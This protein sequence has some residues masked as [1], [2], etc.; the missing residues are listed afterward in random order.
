M[1]YPSDIQVGQLRVV[2]IVED[3]QTGKVWTQKIKHF[4]C[5]IVE[6]NKTVSTGGWT[7]STYTVFYEGKIEKVFDTELYRLETFYK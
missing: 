1:I 5:L 4:V 3:V 6:I 7:S 2:G